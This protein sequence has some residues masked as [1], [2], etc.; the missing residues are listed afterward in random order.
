MDAMFSG[1]HG[2]GDYG[3]ADMGMGDFGGDMGD[4]SGFDVGDMGGG[5]DF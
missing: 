5:F 4:A 2:V 1:M 3:M